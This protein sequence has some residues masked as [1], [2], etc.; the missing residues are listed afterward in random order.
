MPSAVPNLLRSFL[1]VIVGYMV[2]MLVV[3]ALTFILVNTMG[4]PTGH[5]TAGYLAANVVYS[6]LAAAVGGF[7]TAALAPR[8]PVQHAAV[9]GAVML[10]LAVISYRMYAGQ[11]PP[12]YRAMMLVVP[13]LF[14]VAGAALQARNAP[15]RIL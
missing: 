12:W 13:S 10:V 9:L 15:R 7:A 4:I 6:V 3:V 8:K 1:A 14:A 5:P 11:Q 2:M